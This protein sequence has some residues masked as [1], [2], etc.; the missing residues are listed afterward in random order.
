[1]EGCVRLF[2]AHYIFCRFTGIHTRRRD[3]AT[4]AMPIRRMNLFRKSS[5]VIT[6]KANL[7]A[8][9]DKAPTADYIY[10]ATV[11]GIHVAEHRQRMTRQ[12]VLI[13]EVAEMTVTQF[14]DFA[15][16]T[17]ENVARPISFYQKGNQG[18]IVYEFVDLDLVDILPLSHNEIASVMLQV[19]TAP[20]KSK[21]LLTFSTCLIR[22]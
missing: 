22:L 3:K 4:Y 12:L 19:S 11:N 21:V 14:S 6:V 9:P 16:V 17:H 2:L 8:Y 18:S 7:L 10:A 13:Q 1:M 15:K 5:R 20:T